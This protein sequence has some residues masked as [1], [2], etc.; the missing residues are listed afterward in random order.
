MNKLINLIVAIVLCFS[1]LGCTQPQIQKDLT[2]EQMCLSTTGI[3]MVG[4]GVIVK[5]NENKLGGIADEVFILTAHHVIADADPHNVFVTIPDKDGKDQIFIGEINNYLESKDLAMVKVYVK[6][7]MCVPVRL[8]NNLCEVGDKLYAVGYPSG[9][10]IVTQ[11]IS[12]RIIRNNKQTGVF[13]GG[14]VFG[15]SGGGIFNSKGELVG[16]ATKMM[17]NKTESTFL[18]ENNRTQKVY[19]IIPIYHLGYFCFITKEEIDSLL[20]KRYE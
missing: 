12:G 19:P 11:G 16:I 5:I 2:V 15:N 3:S 8:S 7:G 14:I 20:I 13:T 18:D 17:A 9:N 1:F 4:S 6:N 10:L